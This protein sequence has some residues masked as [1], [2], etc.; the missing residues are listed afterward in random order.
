MPKP[1]L[2]GLCLCENE[3]LWSPL[4]DAALHQSSIPHPSA[5]SELAGWQPPLVPV[6]VSSCSAYTAQLFQLYLAAWCFL[7]L[8]CTNSLPLFPTFILCSPTGLFVVPWTWHACSHLKNCFH[9]PN[10]FL[11]ELSI[12]FTPSPDLVLHS[13]VISAVISSQAPY[14]KVYSLLPL[15][16][17]LL[18]IEKNSP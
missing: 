4:A 11:Q 18:P 15:L 2:S 3:I 17:I 5:S 7:S 10:I 16:S 1:H 9:Y 8:L 14:F 12:R 13:N 6:T